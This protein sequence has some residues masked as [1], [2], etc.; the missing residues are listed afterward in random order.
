[1][2]DIASLATVA[3]FAVSVG[4]AIGVPLVV[5]R[6]TKPLQHNGGSSVADHAKAAKEQTQEIRDMLQAH[7]IDSARESGEI[8]A[9]LTALEV[10]RM[11]APQQ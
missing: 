5:N 8:R 10:Q 2:T 9:R 3:T 6:R 4:A 7:L 11:Q 1:M